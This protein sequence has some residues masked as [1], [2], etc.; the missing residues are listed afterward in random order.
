MSFREETRLG[1]GTVCVNPFE[2]RGQGDGS[3]VPCLNNP[4]AINRGINQLERYLEI[5]GK[6]EWEGVLVLYD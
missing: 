5:L 2:K 3:L 4:R 6:D 1:Q